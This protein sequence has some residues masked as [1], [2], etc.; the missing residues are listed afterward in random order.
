MTIRCG[1]Q[2]VT[3]LLLRA[4]ARSDTRS[5]DGDTAMHYAARAGLVPIAE[6]LLSNP[7][8]ALN[9]SNLAGPERRTIAMP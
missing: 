9:A 3:K 4:G 1:Q 5:G 8:L 7:Q 6:L 2:E